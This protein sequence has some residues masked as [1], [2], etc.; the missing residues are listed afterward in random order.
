M[1][2]LRPKIVPAPSVTIPVL[3][4]TVNV[5]KHV[6]SGERFAVVVA[7]VEIPSW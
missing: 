7:S 6:Y 3:L 2:V 4:L 1:T 5:L